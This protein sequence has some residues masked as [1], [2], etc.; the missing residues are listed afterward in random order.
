MARLAR[1]DSPKRT[2]A[3]IKTAKCLIDYNVD[4]DGAEGAADP[5]LA[6]VELLRVVCQSVDTSRGWTMRWP[7]NAVSLLGRAGALSPGKP[8]KLMRALRDNALNYTHQL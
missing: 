3:A 6:A 1:S 8:Y 4:W 5:C 7:K 2:T